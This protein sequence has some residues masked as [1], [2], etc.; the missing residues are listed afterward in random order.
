MDSDKEKTETIDEK[1]EQLA[2][3]FFD[4]PVELI[5]S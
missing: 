1:E 5:G 4:K 3:E 2:V